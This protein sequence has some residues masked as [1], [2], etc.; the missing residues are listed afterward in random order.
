MLRV[1]L[2]ALLFSSGKYFYNDTEFSGIGYDVKSDGRIKSVEI[3]NGVYKCDYRST[4]C[5]ATDPVFEINISGFTED[6]ID[7]YRS[8]ELSS[9]FG[10]S[11]SRVD[12]RCQLLLNEVA[13]TGLA[14]VFDGIF[15]VRELGYCNGFSLT[16]AAWNRS[17]LLQ[18][19]VIENGIDQYYS[20]YSNGGLKSAQ[21]SISE[22]SPDR[23]MVTKMRAMLGFSSENKLSFVSLEGDLVSLEGAMNCAEFFPI[24]KIKDLNNFK[25]I[26]VVYFSGNAISYDEF[27][28]I[29]GSN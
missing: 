5:P 13:Y 7:G 28:K 14:Y 17:G 11:Y 18:N 10:L 3:V 6:D 25:K 2:E 12:M 24:K 19:L 8:D 9:E 29:I 23:G 26:D 20:W 4:F 27:I 1:K 21:L 22:A 15:C 16:D